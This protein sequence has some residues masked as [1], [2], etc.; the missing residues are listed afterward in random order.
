MLGRSVT[1]IFSQVRGWWSSLARGIDSS[2]KDYFWAGKLGK[3]A[4]RVLT[5]EAIKF[6]DLDGG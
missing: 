3:Y 1:K 6:D 2:F 5:I 4:E